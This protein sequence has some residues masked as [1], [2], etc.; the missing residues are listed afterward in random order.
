VLCATAGAQ[1]GHGEKVA[2]DANVLFDSGKSALRPDGRDALDRFI[3]EIH[4][5]ESQSIRAIGHADR[6]G[7]PAA[8]HVLSQQRVDA[9]KAY[10][11]GRGIASSRVQTSARG[12]TQPNTSARECKDADD[13]KNVA[14]MQPDRHVF[15]EAS[16]TRITK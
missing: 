4:G 12:D 14:C 11:I 7:I 6:R 2:F 15:I 1:V 3:A 9:V 8:N 16:G 5:L 10:L 13:T